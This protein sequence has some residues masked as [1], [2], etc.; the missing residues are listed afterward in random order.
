MLE[1]SKNFTN[2]YFTYTYFNL[3]FF[4]LL[5]PQ[6]SRINSIINDYGTSHTI[7]IRLRGIGSGFKEGPTAEELPEPLHFVISVAEEDVLEPV[8]KKISQL[9]EST[10]YELSNHRD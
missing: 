8:C 9:I 3:L 10:K 1:E 4:R 6:V 5:G 7:K 2:T